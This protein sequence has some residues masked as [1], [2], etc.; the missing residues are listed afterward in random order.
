MTRTDLLWDIALV[1]ATI[2]ATVY[3]LPIL[4]AGVVSAAVITLHVMAWT[5][6]AGGI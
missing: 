4:A 3:Y 6:P 1:G 2:G 5:H